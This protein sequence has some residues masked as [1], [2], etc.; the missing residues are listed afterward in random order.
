[1]KY[2]R[3]V[4][5]A[6]L[7]VVVVIVT[8]LLWKTFSGQLDKQSEDFPEGTVWVCRDCGKGFRKSISELHE[9]Y[10][11]APGAPV[12]CPHCGKTNTARARQCPHCG[13]FFER[14]ARAQDPKQSGRP[15][16]PKC[17]KALPRLTRVKE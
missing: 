11:D 14:P 3:I 7:V 16:C 10:R 5:A 6:G 13:A 15:A 9:I 12:P 1:M 17:R 4:L 8:V 2:Q